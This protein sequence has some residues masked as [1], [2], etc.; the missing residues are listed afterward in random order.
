MVETIPTA[1]ATSMTISNMV[2]W[3]FRRHHIDPM[4]QTYPAFED[5]FVGDE[6][7]VPLA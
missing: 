5:Y 3:E 2:D 1:E 7:C 4:I 6:C